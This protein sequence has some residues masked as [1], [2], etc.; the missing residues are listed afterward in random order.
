MNH[1]INIASSVAELQDHLV[2]TLGPIAAKYN[3]DFEAFGK[4][5]D[6]MTCGSDHFSKGPKAGRAVISVAY[7]ST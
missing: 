5:I 6:F 1:R 3:L 7:N 4:E 2:R